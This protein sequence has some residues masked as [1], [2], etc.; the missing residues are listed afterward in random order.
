MSPLEGSA[1][2]RKLSGVTAVFPAKNDGGTIASMV[3]TARASLQQVAETHEII[4][5]DNGSR[6]Y[7]SLVL[8]ELV[9][10]IPELRVF[11]HPQTLGYG[12]AL[13]EGFS[14]ATKEWIFYTDGDA[15]YDPLELTTLAEALHEGISVVNGYKTGRKDPLHRRVFGFLYHHIARILFGFR[16]KDVDCDF[17]LFRRSILEAVPLE[18]TTGTLGLEMVKRF[19]DAG[20]LFAEVPVSHYY[21]R[22][23]ESQFFNIRRLLF[24]ARQIFQLWIKLVLQ[25]RRLR[26]IRR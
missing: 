10:F 7:T 16:L 19:Q 13:R 1:A 25:K 12:G 17:R 22:Y 3:L 2:S 23:G 5:V 4:V 9:R 20:Y 21:R 14:A 18:S 26:E 15:Q 8:D 11:H 24:T 6:D